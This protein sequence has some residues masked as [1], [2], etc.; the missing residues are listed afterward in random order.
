MA[1]KRESQVAEAAA[2]AVVTG[3]AAVGGK[4]AK[5]KL[6]ASRAR[7][8]ERAYRLERGEFVP[9]GMRRIAR[10]QLDQG[11]EELD[12]QPNRKLDEAVHETRKRLKRLRAALRLERFA[13]GDETYRRENATFRD[14]GKRLSAPRDAMVKIET[15]DALSERFSDELPPDQTGPVRDR[16][17]QSHKRA[18]AKLRR[19]R[20]TLDAV[21]AE[22][23]QARVRSASWKYDSEGFEAL[24]PGLQRIYR[25]GRRSMRAAADEPSDEHLHGWRKR[26]KDLWHALQILRPAAPKRMKAPAKRAHRLSDLLGEDHDLAVL[27]EHI[28]HADGAFE[29]EAT[30]TALLSAIDRRRGSL[31]REALKLGA[32]V[33]GRRPKRFARAVERGWQKRAAKQPEPIAGSRHARGGGSR[34]RA[35]VP[36]LG[37][38]RQPRSRYPHPPGLRAAHKRGHRAPRTQEGQRDGPDCQARPRPGLR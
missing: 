36:R 25:R 4:L 21:R 19:D 11:I 17:E 6:T 8:A 9:D 20:A 1:K 18:V 7:E 33:Y 35:Q 38:P 32:R 12:G 15:L 31:Q 29:Q 27:R 34:D 28:G 2:V 23:E 10:G 14:L 16:L 24:S 5:D 22:F 13:V 30:R 3:A 26:A 37:N